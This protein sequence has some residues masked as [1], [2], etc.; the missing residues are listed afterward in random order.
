MGTSNPES[1]E[2]NS[3]HSREINLTLPDVKRI[4]DVRQ[5]MA[6]SKNFNGRVEKLMEFIVGQ[7]KQCQDVIKLLKDQVQQKMHALHHLK[8]DMLELQRQL[9]MPDAAKQCKKLMVKLTDETE[10]NECDV[11][12]ALARFSLK[13]SSLYCAILELDSDVDYANYLANVAN[14]N[15]EFVQNWLKSEKLNKSKISTIRI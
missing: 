14:V 4:T 12:E 10:I 9:N 6:E 8:E 15:K 2:L 11:A 13:M 1:T 5:F 7:E 3:I